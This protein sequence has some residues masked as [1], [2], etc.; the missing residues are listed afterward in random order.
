VWART[1]FDGLFV[2]VICGL[3]RGI[4]TLL[5]GVERVK[6]AVPGRSREHTALH[7]LLT[8]GQAAGRSGRDPQHVALSSLAALTLSTWRRSVIM[9]ATEPGKLLQGLLDMLGADLPRTVTSGLLERALPKMI[10]GARYAP[11]DAQD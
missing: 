11:G 4:V 5:D 2:T 1:L 6:A 7:N 8:A 9:D 3:W 10:D